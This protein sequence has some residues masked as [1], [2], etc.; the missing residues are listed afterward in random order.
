MHLKRISYSRPKAVDQYP[1]SLSF[2]Q[3]DFFIDLRTPIT[4][5]VGTNGAGKSTLLEGV[6]IKSDL[7]TIG[8]EQSEN[9][10]T[11]VAQKLLSDC[12]TLSYNIRTRKGFFMRSED[13]FGFKKRL[14][15]TSDE[16]N[17]HAKELG[18]SLTGYGKMLALGA[19]KGQANIQDKSYD[20]NLDA[21]S[22]GQTFLKLIEKRVNPNGLYLMDEPETP[23]SFENQLR[24][25]YQLR[26]ATKENCQ[27]I[28]A[29]HSPVLTAIPDCTILNFEN[30][31]PRQ[32]TYEQ[33]EQFAL[34]KTFLGAPQR[35]FK[36]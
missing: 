17:M 34:L 13:V 31:G 24:L 29:T 36:D 8:E 27:F 25:A 7:P 2:L 33:I 15:K 26:Q 18:D 6:A 21:R 5:F 14:D 35:F 30:G 32:I 11:L 28:I 19:T 16:L 3:K 12:L 20:G 1:F 4:F 22:H 9:D 23:L 10:Y